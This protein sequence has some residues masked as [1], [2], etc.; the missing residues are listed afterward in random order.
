MT[1]V[2]R[3]KAEVAGSMHDKLVGHKTPRALLS[4]ENLLGVLIN[5]VREE[6]AAVCFTQDHPSVMTL[7]MN[8]GWE[9]ACKAIANAIRSKKT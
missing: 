2:E 9:R 6:D 4:T 7:E 8:R 5:A 1:E 3:L